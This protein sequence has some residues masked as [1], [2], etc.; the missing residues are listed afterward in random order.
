MLIS[1]EG[2]RYDVNMTTRMR[3]PVFWE[4]NPS[5]VRRCSWFY[6]ADGDS[7]FVPYEEDF[8]ARLEVCKRV[9]VYK[10]KKSCNEF[11]I[12]STKHITLLFAAC[13]DMGV[14]A[15]ITHFSRNENR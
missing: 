13:S 7:R 6:K 10:L 9:V 3:N 8:A 2:G 15:E 1:V 11:S 5:Q 12:E 14:Q 4:E